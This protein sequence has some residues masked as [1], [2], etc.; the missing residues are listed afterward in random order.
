MARVIKICS[1][2]LVTFLLLFSCFIAKP[3][4]ADSGWDADYGGSSDWGSSSSDWGSS[5]SDWDW[6]SDSDGY[7][8]SSDVDAVLAIVI[9]LIFTVAIIAVIVTTP[10]TASNKSSDITNKA[11]DLLF[12]LDEFSEYNT[13]ELQLE[14]FNVY[15]DIQ[16]AWSKN[17]LEPVRDLLTD[18]L[19]NTYKMQV[20]TMLKIKQRNVMKSFF[21]NK[22]N[23]IDIT[24]NNN[25]EQMKV[26]MEV[27]CTDY[28]VQ[29]INGKEQV[30]KGHDDRRMVYDYQM[31]FV[32]NIKKITKKCPNCGNKLNDAMSTKCEYCGGIV[33]HETDHFV[34]SKKE[35][36][37]QEME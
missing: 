30:I 13:E 7:Y 11:I 8:V 31:T 36:L 14:L 17:D 12:D 9:I 26:V 21:M 15:K 3:V 16:I 33:V 34:L 27:K 6:G 29:E 37:K 18:E 24:R 20:D 4:I 23:I 10:R 32:R 5:S 2:S 28:V 22:M 25:I 19:F 35:M 1:I